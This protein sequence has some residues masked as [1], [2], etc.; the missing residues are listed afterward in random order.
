MWRAVL[1]LC[2]FAACTVDRK[3]EQFAC[4]DG[5]SCP[6]G[7]HCVDGY[8]I[9]GATDGGPGQDSN[10]CPSPCDSCD[11]AAR[12]CQVLCDS[13]NECSSIVCPAGYTCAISCLS[14]SACNFVNCD[15]AAA[16]TV[17]CSGNRACGAITCGAGPCDVT[18]TSTNSC[19]AI[20][21]SDSC[22]CDVDCNAGNCGALACPGGS[23][24]QSCTTDGNF[25]SP[26]SSSAQ[27]GCNTCP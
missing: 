7:R 8:C 25:G 22:R 20:S 10:N 18:C 11:I 23:G 13:A 15:Q 12:T 3:T 21:C 27:D 17:T 2:L 16:C 6:S 24:A 1:A 9:S 4:G 19:D 14:N 26:C 5:D